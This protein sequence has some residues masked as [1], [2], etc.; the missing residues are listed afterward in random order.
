M[1]VKLVPDQPSFADSGPGYDLK[2]S[3]GI[4]RDCLFLSGIRGGKPDLFSSL[5]SFPITESRPPKE[6]Y[7]FRSGNIIWAAWRIKSFRNPVPTS[8]WI[9]ETLVSIDPGWLIPARID[10]KNYEANFG[11]NLPFLY[12]LTVGADQS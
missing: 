12:S 4:T 3:L 11:W 9:L 1:T 7:L 2:L 8:L 10:G 6:E 5:G